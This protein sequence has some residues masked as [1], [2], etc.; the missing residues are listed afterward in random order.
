MHASH[1]QLGACVHVYDHARV[2]VYGHARVHVY[3]HAR[4]HVD[5]HAC[6]HV[7]E[8]ARASWRRPSRGATASNRIGELWSVTWDVMWDVCDVVPRCRIGEYPIDAT[9]NLRL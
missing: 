5:G 7:D 2:Y 9:S 4:V 6:V 3:G 1:M 8:H